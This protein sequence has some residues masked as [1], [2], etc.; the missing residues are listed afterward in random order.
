M[1]GWAALVFICFFYCL[2]CYWE[3]QSCNR[4]K[5]I[6]KIVRMLDKAMEDM[7][8]EQRFELLKATKLT[9]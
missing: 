9:S 8:P 5:N 2:F 1:S 6:E 4:R 7:T 3:T